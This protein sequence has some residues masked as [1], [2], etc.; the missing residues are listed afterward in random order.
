MPRQMAAD[1]I[2]NIMP[3]R[4]S[5]GNNG[6]GNLPGFHDRANQDNIADGRHGRHLQGSGANGN[7]P[8][9]RHIPDT[10]TQK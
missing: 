6:D 1:A 4:F 5:K 10:M 7:P 3:D 2:L 9:S 8:S